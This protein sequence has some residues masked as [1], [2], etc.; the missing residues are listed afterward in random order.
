MADKDLGKEVSYK[1]KLPERKFGTFAGVFMPS[2]LTILGA[3]MYLILPQVLGGVGLLKT[4]IIILIAHSVTIATA[5]SISAIA[6]NI[7]VKGGGLYYLISRSLGSEFGGSLGIQLYLAQTI[8]ASFYAIAFARGFGVVLTYFGLGIPEMYLALISLILFGVMVFIGAQF[9][10]KLQYFIFAAIVLSLVSIFLGPNTVDLTSVAITASGLS[11][12]V[13]FAM[14]FPAVTGI[15]AGVGMSGELKD[16]KKSLV[17][18]TFLAILVTMIVYLALVVKLAFSAT[19]EQLFTNPQVLNSVALFSPLI[20]L[21]IIMATSSSALSSLM[22]SPRCLVAMAEDKVLPRFLSFLGKKS[23]KNGEPRIAIVFSLLIGGGIIFLGSLELVSQIVSMFFLSV[24]GWINGSAFFEKISHNPSYRPT[25]NA[26]AYVS[27]YGMIAAYLVMFLFNPLIMFLVIIIQGL[28]FYSL[29]KSNKSMKIEG[30]WAG[31]SFRF[32]KLFLRSMDRNA[33][34]VKNWRPT[35]LAFS[36]KE[37]NNHPIASLLHWISSKSSITKM[38]FLHKGKV[39]QD[40]ETTK[41]HQ[42]ALN[43]YVRENDLDLFPRSIASEDFQTTI[44]TLSQA[45]TVGNLPLNTILLDFDN[46]L[47]LNE[48]TRDLKALDKNL[49]IMRNQSGFSGFKK[50]DVWW[51]SRRNGNF[52]IL[53][54]YLITHSTRWLEEGAMIRV[55]NI[56]DGSDENK[57]DVKHI[58][59]VLKDSRIENIE[60]EIISKGERKIE[61]IINDVSAGSDLVIMGLTNLDK[62]SNKKIADHIEKFTKK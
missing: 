52:M 18:G 28:L 55:L 3:V 13:A 26:P 20:I 46:A 48:L 54:A 14:F 45:E 43:S 56:S 39:G 58:E 47:K 33:S 19:S 29:Y 4:I 17:K 32:M 1:K 31:V 36:T 40:E 57:K 50:V 37:I 6:T 16:P 30:V 51:S 11:F 8:A 61:E 5:Y 34:T 12:W 27:F 25:F 38:Y 10:V 9:V 59:G 15:D 7:Q 44:G 41:H 62:T 49:I 2:L 53:L 42:Q 21:G 24:Y 22:T 23:K 60:L 35:L